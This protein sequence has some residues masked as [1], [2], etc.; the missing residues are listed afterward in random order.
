[1]KKD[2][3]LVCC[4]FMSV[5]LSSCLG[6]VDSSS[7]LVEDSS[8]IINEDSSSLKNEDS[9]SSKDPVSDSSSSDELV[10]DVDDTFD[11][12]A[13]GIGKAKVETKKELEAYTPT[14]FD[15]T[16]YTTETKTIIDGVD[17]VVSSLKLNNG[18]TV[19][20]HSVV[21]DLSKANIVAG[22][23]DNV[24]SLNDLKKGTPYA[25]A[26]A[27]ESAN[28]GVKV[29]AATNA[30]FFGSAPVHAFVK[31][32]VIVKNA[33]NSDA[34]DVPVSAPMLFGV[35]N[36][37]AQ[38]GPMTNLTNYSENQNAKLTSVGITLAGADGS[39]KGT[40]PF[41]FDTSPSNDSIAVITKLNN[42]KNFTEGTKVYKF[43]K[44][45]TSE[46]QDGEV[47]GCIVEREYVNRVKVTDERFGYLILG[48]KFKDA[49]MKVGD[50]FVT[51]KSVFSKGGLWD[52]Y[53]TILGARH[54][55]VENGVIPETVAKE[56]Q[57][58]AASR[59]PR[60][61]IGVKSDGKVV[62]VSVEDIHYGSKEG[63][64]TGMTL[65]QL[66]DFMRY[67]GCY[68]A[69][70]FDGGGSSQLITRNSLQ[71]DFVVKTRSSDYRTYNV[72]QTRAVINSILVTTK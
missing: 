59:V 24:T 49:T 5:T 17:L 62:I 63:T 2:K 6:T 30:D 8:S 40:Y 66:A 26:T 16:S 25:H 43:M 61:A 45:Q 42:A 68:D 70:N 18:I 50:Y 23:T 51:K 33:H 19:K 72:K 39:N 12:S 31:D 44:I 15:K 58:G 20:P 4:A 21:V 71:E 54:S 38:I 3:L 64:C 14:T 32:G 56:W 35:S 65:S 69:A 46:C 67:F 13:F 22:T 47:R 7:S 37:G 34:S 1:M 60:T 29:V 41:S 11:F 55:L 27:Y 57:N 10:Y 52:H 28:P 48:S 9:S 53:H 36:E